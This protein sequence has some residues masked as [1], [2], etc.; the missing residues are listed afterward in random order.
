MK[1]QILLDSNII[2]YS[3]NAEHRIILEQLKQYELSAS[4]ISIIEVLGF[5]RLDPFEK[6][7]YELFFN[8][9][10]LYDIDDTIIQQATKFRQTKKMSVGDAIISATALIYQLPLMTRNDGDFEWIDSLTIINPFNKV[11]TNS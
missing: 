1:S 6:M 7:E 5:H 8:H 10:K 11:K 2:I 4:K 9:I 3:T